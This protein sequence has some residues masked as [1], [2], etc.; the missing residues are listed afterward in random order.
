ME[1]FIQTTLFVHIF[2]GGLALL[3]GITA[4]LSKKGQKVHIQ[5]GRIY[6]WSMMTVIVTAVIMALFRDNSFLQSIAVFSFYLA[7]TGKRLLRYKK[8]ITPQAID[9]IMSTISLLVAIGM[10]FAAV[11]IMLQIGF[12]GEAPVLLV[13]GF[14]LFSMSFQDLI[15]MK[16]KKFVKNAW[17]F[18]HIG[19][20]S[21]SFIATTTA[22]LV[23]NFSLNPPWL[24]WLLPTFI[25]T[26]LIFV[27]S[28]KW[29]KKL[30]VKT[31]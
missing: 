1:T 7:F 3:S 25:G 20:M 12:A 24:L 26:P 2:A 28:M 18:D 22:F 29:R 16:R 11:K 6:F 4:I 17:L 23:V 8:A 27:A 15:K 5:S 21:G 13:F 14:F 19:R 31:K 30:G 10:L 9:W